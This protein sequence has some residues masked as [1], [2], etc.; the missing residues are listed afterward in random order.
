MAQ[1]KKQ[2]GRRL[3]PEDKRKQR[4][5]ILDA[6]VEVSKN[7][8][9]AHITREQVAQQA[10]I[11]PALVSSYLGTVPKFRRDVM[12]RAVAVEALEVIAQGLVIKDPHAM[13]AD[14]ELKQRAI[15]LVMS[16]A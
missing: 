16:G 14:E 6:A 10:G 11:S 3:T 7:H 2:Q 5:A 4:E 8:G 12:R 1:I 15:A 9:Y 13:K